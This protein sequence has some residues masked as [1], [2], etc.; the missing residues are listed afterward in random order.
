MIG[1]GTMINMACIVGGGV[2]GLL[3]GRF[4]PARVQDGLNTA[5]GVSVLFVGIAGGL[6]GMLAVTENGLETA[7]SLFVVIALAAGTLL[8]EGID[9]EK[10][11]ERLG[12]WLKQK[13]GNAKD[14]SFVGAFVTASLTVCVCAM[15]VVGSLQDGLTGDYSLLATKG[16]MDLIL[17]MVMACT[18]GKGAVFSAIPLGL[19]Q[20]SITL[21]ASLLRPY[22]TDAAMHNLSFIG[23]ILIF[24]VGLNIVFDRK[25]RVANMLPALIFAIAAAFI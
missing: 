18:L 21:L 7:N 6:T 1:L 3:F 5:C 8:G 23:S 24:C 9:L 2:F 25:I 20:G 15:A 22:V 13:T 10:Y 11:M 4:I 12:S 19:I 14:A 16:L 17:I